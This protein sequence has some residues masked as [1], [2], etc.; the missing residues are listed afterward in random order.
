MIAPERWSPRT[1]TAVVASLAFAL[2]VHAASFDAVCDDAFISLRYAR[3]LA[4][5]GAPVYNLGER[6]E[7][8]SSPVWMLL[9]AVLLRFGIEG[10]FVLTMLGAFGGVALIAS[11]WHLWNVLVPRKP[12]QG[13]L[14]LAMVAG[15]TPVAAWTSSGLET[16]LFAALVAGFVAEVA[17]CSEDPTPRRALVVGLLS[18][19]ATLTRPEGVFV[20]VLGFVWFAAQKKTRDATTLL[21]FALGALAPL[22]VFEAWRFA[23][24][25]AL[26]PNTHR[27]KVSAATGERMANGL[28]YTWFAITETSLGLSALLLAGLVVP[29]RS[30]G[31]W[32]ARLVVVV[33][34]AYVVW[35]GGDFLDLF[36]F[37]VPVLPLLYLSLVASS[38]GLVERLGAPHRSWALGAV[39]TLPL[40]ALA[41]VKLRIHALTPHESAREAARIEPLIWTREH[42]TIWADAGR[43]V[44]AHAQPGDT[45]AVMAAGAT[46]FYADLPTLDMFGLTD[47]EVAAHGDPNGVRPGH[48]RFARFDHVLEKRPTFLMFDECE[49]P[50]AWVGWKWTDAGYECVIVKAPKSSG[51][52][53]RLTFLLQRE[54]ADDLGRRKI[55]YR[56]K[57]P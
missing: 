49:L 6:V 29:T 22:L 27:A 40:F 19:L 55:A 2:V 16:P 21:P 10:R 32:L 52:E 28:R 53:M 11:V 34:V 41:Q 25:G 23:Y 1:R 44:A 45:M 36:R 37:F 26:L 14:V 54:R 43:F 57:R 18:A 9:E 17:S 51:G 33:F 15:S 24:Y 39:L 38:L 5:H 7:G 13:L 35:V 8:Y 56:F 12:L 30:R 50:A 31:L 3:N 47:A 48:Q 4:L 20:C 42:G 46:P